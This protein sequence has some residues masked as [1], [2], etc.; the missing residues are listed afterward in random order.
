MAWSLIRENWMTFFARLKTLSMNDCRANIALFA[1]LISVGRISLA[2]N[3]QM[4]DGAIVRGPID[5]KEIALVFTAHT[6]GEGGI[7]ILDELKRHQ[8][9]A[10]FFF[11]GAF[12]EN[13]EFGEIVKRVIAEGHYLGPHSDQHLLYADWNQPGKMLVSRE[14]FRADLEANLRKIEA[15]EVKQEK[16]RYFLPAYEQANPTI[17]KWTRE[18]G[19]VLVDYTPGTRSNADY[20]SESEKNF[21]SSEKIFRSIVDKERKDKHGLNG[22]ILLTHLGSGPARKDKF[23]DRFGELLDYLSTRGYRFVRIDE[24]LK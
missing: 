7:K 10:S 13:P 14:E 8:A 17:A 3:Y 9:K 2:A 16:V 5:Q 20:T 1:I 4:Q 15:L 18:M 11:T 23:A 21:V 12:L 22:F 24:L 6:F 19:M